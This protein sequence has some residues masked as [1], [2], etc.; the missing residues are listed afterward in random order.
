M[1]LFVG[2]RLDNLVYAIRPWSQ[3][4]SGVAL[5]APEWR[6]VRWAERGQRILDLRVRRA[7]D[8]AACEF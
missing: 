4:R 6:H 8:N 5:E 3:A 1:L 2:R 7:I